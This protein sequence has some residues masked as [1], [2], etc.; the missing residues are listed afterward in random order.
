M[1]DSVITGFYLINEKY[2]DSVY[3]AGSDFPEKYIVWDLGFKCGALG[4]KLGCS[5]G[6]WKMQVGSGQ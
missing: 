6:D 3:Y 2:F 1:I 4:V 5:T